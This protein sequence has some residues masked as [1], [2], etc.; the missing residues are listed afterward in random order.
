MS[1]KKIIETFVLA[2][3]LIIF[4]GLTDP[5]NTSLPLILIPYILSALII[6]R[7]LLIL[8]NIALNHSV[9]SSKLRLYSLVTTAILINFALLKSIGQITFQ[10]ALISLAIMIVSVVYIS[11]FS[12]N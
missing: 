6:Y 2:G 9:K 7:V 11:K 3:L 5:N 1:F 8:L 4:L 10:D 12:F